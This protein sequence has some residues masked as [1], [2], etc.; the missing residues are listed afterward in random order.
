MIPEKMPIS[1]LPRP[2]PELPGDPRKIAIV[3]A[4]NAALACALALRRMEFGGK[5]SMVNNMDT[6]P[7]D[8]KKIQIDFDLDR[9]PETTELISG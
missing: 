9:I 4:G 3:G 5:I 6:F 7:Y 8:K 2:F 1:L